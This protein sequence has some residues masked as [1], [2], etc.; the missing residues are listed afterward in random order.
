MISESTTTSGTATQPASGAAAAAVP[1]HQVTAEAASFVAGIAYP[2]LPSELVELGKMHILDALGLAIAGQRAETGPIVRQY[3]GELGVLN[4]AS[5]VLGTT[6]TAPPRFA[7][8]ANG[9]AIH[10]DDF[11][12]TQLAV[13]KDRVYGLLTHP[14]VTSVPSALAM[15]EAH[16]S[17]G[18]DFMLAYHV[19]LEVET[20]ICEAI[21]PRSYESGFHSTGFCG[22]FG[23]AASAGKLRGLDT[24]RLCN[25]FGIAGA[26]ASGLRENFGT[27]TKPF[28]AGHAAEAG[29]TAADLAALGWTAAQNILEAKRGFFTAYGGGWDPDAV[30]GKFGKPW[31][32]LTPGVSIKPYPTGSLTH[33]AMDAMLDLIEA[34]HIQAE[35]V[36][37]VRVGTNKQMLNTLIHR[38]PR[39]GLQGKFSM[40]YCMAVLLVRGRAGLGE[41]EDDVV[42]RPELQEMLR[43]VDFY[44]NPQADAAGADKMR[45][46]VEVRLK[47]GRVFSAQN[48]FAKGS[49]QKPMSFDDTVQ[50]FRGCTDFAGVAR[51][52]ADRIISIVQDLETVDRMSSVFKGLFD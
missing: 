25:L 52:K 22:V 41:F 6:L 9:V 14:T 46:Y 24:G 26:Q 1:A 40:E 8:F 17:S 39:T 27:M 13:A 29:M 50:K 23:S 21:A 4:G 38:Q 45:S 28:Q 31:S 10:A 11:D 16:G 48:D 47:D 33:P 51:S 15:A 7:A 3:L 37:Q 34:N 30:A 36:A 12:D 2:D 44:N 19:G 49:P 5:T 18:R 43:R 20:K 42:N 32:L 35:D